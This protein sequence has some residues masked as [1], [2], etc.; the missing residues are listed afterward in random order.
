MGRDD[1]SI[2]WTGGKRRRS[3]A[4]KEQL[5]TARVNAST[6][7]L[8][9]QSDASTKENRFSS[10]FEQAKE[11][12]NGYQ[13][14][15]YNERKK[16]KRSH[17]ANTETRAENG[18]LRAEV[19]HLTAEV[20]SLRAESS[21]LR[22]S[23]SSQKSARSQLSQKLHRLTEKCRRIPDRL[24]TVF[25]KATAKAK[26]EITE[27]FSFTMKE[28]GVVPDSTRDMIN[29]L[30]ALDGVRPNKVIGVLKRIADKLGIEVTGKASDRTV[31]RIVKE[32][33]VAPKMQFVEAVGTSKGLHKILFWIPFIL[34]LNLP[35]FCF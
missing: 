9:T 24:D 14:S 7:S 2:R 34:M 4:Q 15:L 18:H 6:A 20:A 29:D 26:D 19:G 16:L 21:S 5:L 27:L 1:P 22:A 35:P 28:K 11:R 8:R 30:V 3:Q 32:G 33:G 31:R 23:L 10:G 25:N 12:A 13:R 17:V